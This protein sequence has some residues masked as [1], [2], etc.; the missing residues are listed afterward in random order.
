[1]STHIHIYIYIYI[2]TYTWQH[3]QIGK[4]FKKL[5]RLV[6]WSVWND[7]VV[8]RSSLPL[9]LS[10]ASSLPSLLRFVHTWSRLLL[11]FILL[12]YIFICCKLSIF[13]S[14][15]SPPL[16]A[17]V[18]PL[19]ACQTEGKEAEEDVVCHSRV[20]T[21]TYLCMLVCAYVHKFVSINDC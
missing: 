5:L 20:L 15:F 1:M 9:L 8:G 7:W 4:T 6:L 19:Q 12:F 17:P 3:Q 16:T 2:L 21:F 11:F 10:L 18:M 13:S 14:F